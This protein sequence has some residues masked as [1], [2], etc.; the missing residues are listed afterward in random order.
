MNTVNE[1]IF[2]NGKIVIP[3]KEVQFIEK[4]KSGGLIIVFKDTKWN[5]EA[6]CW[7]NNA[8][9][10]ASDADSFLQA[11]CM[12]RHELEIDDLVKN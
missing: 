4:Q 12:Y 5:V 2:S 9:I 8:F 6:D 1:S 11:W 7:Q 10:T 3:M